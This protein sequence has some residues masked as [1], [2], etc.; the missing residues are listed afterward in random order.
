M[1]SS[2]AQIKPRFL[3]LIHYVHSYKR[4]LDLRVRTENSFAD[5]TSA[6]VP[7]DRADARATAAARCCHVASRGAAFA[8]QA[9]RDV[10]LQPENRFIVEKVILASL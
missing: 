7:A 10:A 6:T 1:T 3:S 4:A 9:A 2:E 5:A 8:T